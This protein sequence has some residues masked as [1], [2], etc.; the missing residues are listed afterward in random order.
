MTS[1]D[2]TDRPKDTCAQF[3]VKSFRRAQKHPM[4]RQ[5]CAYM[6]S[7]GAKGKAD[8]TLSTSQPVP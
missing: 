2:N 3:V 5:M 1:K 8:S 7:T 6:A 4:G